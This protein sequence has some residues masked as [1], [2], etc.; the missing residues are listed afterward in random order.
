[1]DFG[2]PGESWGLIP[3]GLVAFSHLC[4]SSVAVNVLVWAS[5]QEYLIA[6]PMT[7]HEDVGASS[8]ATYS[9]TERKEMVV[10]ME[11]S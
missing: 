3:L 1:M 4:V 5:S 2:E 10:L 8:V 9:K 6:N 11:L 7:D